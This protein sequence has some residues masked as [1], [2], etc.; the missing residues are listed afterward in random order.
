MAGEALKPGEPSNR[1]EGNAAG[2]KLRPWT[3]M[4]E[5]RECGGN[6]NDGAAWRRVGQG[7]GKGVCVQLKRHLFFSFFQSWN[8]LEAFE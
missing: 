4:E 6:Q 2:Q 8:T 1:R 7:V 3:M 5:P